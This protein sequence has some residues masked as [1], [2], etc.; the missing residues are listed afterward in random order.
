M[1][2]STALPVCGALLALL[3][4]CAFEWRQRRGSRDL[5]RPHAPR[6][7]FSIRSPLLRG[8]YRADDAG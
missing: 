8:S 7:P 1:S 3:V 2:H 4:A 6:C 5:T